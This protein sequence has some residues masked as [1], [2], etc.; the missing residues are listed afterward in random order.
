ME[1][2]FTWINLLILFGA[3]Q[4]LIFGVIL[5]LNKRHPGAKYLGVLMLVLAYNGFETVGWSAGLENYTFIFDLFTFVWIFGLGPSLYLYVHSLLK[6]TVPISKNDVIIAYSPVAFQFSVR[7]IILFIYIFAL[8][9]EQG[10]GWMAVAADLFS[11]YHLYSE[12]LSVIVFLFYLYL[13][14]NLYLEAKNEKV[15]QSGRKNKTAILKWLR[16]LLVCLVALGAFWPLVLLL[17]YVS[18]IGFDNHYYLLELLL[19]LFIYWIAFV[20]Y[21]KIK[22]L[23]PESSSKG[24]SKVPEKEAKQYLTKLKEVMYQDKLYLDA[25]LNREKVANHIGVN[26]KILSM[27]LNQ[28]AEQNFNDFVNSYRVDEVANRLK[29]G[30]HNHLTISGVALESGFN[31]QATFQRV[32]KT[33]KGMSPKEFQN[34][35]AAP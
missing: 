29:S 19:V 4:G 21:H 7:A 5:L 15:L 35:E 13:S 16:V 14:I 12:P 31:S 11:Y 33:I 26:V 6:P 28:Y 30:D 34:K 24:I 10:A 3:L 27:V 1:L 2:D 25:E 8:T 23:H 32:F 20:G 9:D 22:I 18:D 17:P